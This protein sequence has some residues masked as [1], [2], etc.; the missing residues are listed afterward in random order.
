[1]TVLCCKTIETC[2]AAKKEK[3]KENHARND[4]LC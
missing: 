3:K 2:S 4:E 1:M